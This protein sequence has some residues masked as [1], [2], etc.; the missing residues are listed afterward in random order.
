MSEETMQKETTGGECNV[1][2]NDLLGGTV[3]VRHRGGWCA[4]RRKRARYSDSVPTVCG[5]YVALPWGVERREPDCQE[6]V[7][8]LAVE[9]ANVTPNKRSSS[10]A[11]RIAPKASRANLSSRES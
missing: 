11:D 2:C 5:F 10:L 9:R 8:R 7:Q 6:C 3:S 1:R 4:T